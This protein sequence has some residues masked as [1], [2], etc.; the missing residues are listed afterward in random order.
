MLDLRNAKRTGHI[1]TLED[2]IEY[3]FRNKK[4]IVNQREIGTRRVEPA[5]SRCA[6]RCGR[7]PTA[8]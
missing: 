7:R 6:T 2:P 1:L 3:V 4:S 5:T 8:S